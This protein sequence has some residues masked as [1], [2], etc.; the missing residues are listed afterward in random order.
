MK[1]TVRRGG[2]EFNTIVTPGFDDK[3]GVGYAGWWEKGEIQIENPEVVE[4]SYPTFWEDLKK[5][6]FA[7]S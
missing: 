5:A 7:I 6:G 4:K 2:K 1:V 3:N